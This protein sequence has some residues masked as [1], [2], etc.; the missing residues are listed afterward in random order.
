MTKIKSLVVPGW[1]KYIPGF[2]FCLAFAFAGMNL[3]HVISKY[4]KANIASGKIAEL[5]LQRDEL[6]RTGDKDGQ[7]AAVQNSIEKHRKALSAV[8]GSVGQ[9]WEWAT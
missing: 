4:H 3:D 2:L 6:T 5:E 1:Q 9:R 8:D 7:L